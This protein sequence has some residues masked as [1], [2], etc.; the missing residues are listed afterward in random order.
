MTAI[1][2][3]SSSRAHRLTLTALLVVLAAATAAGTSVRRYVMHSRDF[4]AI[5]IKGPLQVECRVN[6][7]ST[8]M[9]VFTADDDARKAVSIAHAAGELHI[10]ARPAPGHRLSPITVYTPPAL[11]TVSATGEARIVMAPVEV[12]TP[13]AL[14]VNGPGAI[15]APSVTAPSVSLSLSGRGSLKADALSATTLNCSAA[16]SGHISVTD[17]E[18]RRLTATVRGTAEVAASGRAAEADVVV[19]GDG[20]V[21]LSA[22]RCP[23]LKA[24]VY[25][26]GAV[27]CN[28]SSAVRADGN[29]A[30]IAAVRPQS[31]SDRQTK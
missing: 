15:T 30:R 21:D 25:G 4:D 22:L 2:P 18:V 7:D 28:P 3:A 31:S 5:H 29:T 19:K 12:A 24:A 17:A 8:G 11:S 1:N 23:K 10:V 6:P 14:V 26:E 13:L 16:G 20:S 9:I 27:A